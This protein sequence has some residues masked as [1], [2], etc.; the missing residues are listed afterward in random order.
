LILAL[1]LTSVG[2]GLRAQPVVAPEYQLKAVFLYHFAQFVEWPPGTFASPQ[3]PLVIGVLGK[4]PFGAFLDQIVSGE[5]VDHRGL[6]VRRYARVEDVDACQI[7]FISPSGSSELG[8]IL[9]ALKGRSIL[10]VGDASDFA[11][12]G[13]MIGLVTADNRIRFRINLGAAKAAHL[14]LSSNLLRPAEIVATEN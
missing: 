10:T 6:R 1:G 13:G 7:L 2:S 12:A 14:T 3:A 8:P 5:S 11:R 9:Q 4:D